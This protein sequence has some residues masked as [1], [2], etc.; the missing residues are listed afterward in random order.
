MPYRGHGIPGLMVG[1]IALAASRRCLD[2]ALSG[3]DYTT[4]L[5]MGSLPH[6][7]RA[8]HCLCLALRHGTNM[9]AVHLTGMHGVKVAM[10]SQA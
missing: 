9:E 5:S 3:A 6:R 7:G 10:V 8:G 2:V 4:T 1:A